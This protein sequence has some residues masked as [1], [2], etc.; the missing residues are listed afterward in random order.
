MTAAQLLNSIYEA[1]R[2][3]VASRTPAWGSDKGNL[4]I[5]IANRKQREWCTDPRNKWNSLFEIR[6]LSPVLDVT[7]TPTYTYNLAADFYQPSDFVKIVKNDSSIVVYPIVKAQQRNVELQSLYIHGSNPKK[8]T[9]S[10]IVDKGLEGATMY[11]PGYYLLADLANSTD[12][13][14]VDDPN[15]LVYATAAELARNDPAKEDNYPNLI[16]MANELYARMSN[17]NNDAGFGQPNAVVNFMPNVG[18]AVED[19]TL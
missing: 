8:I 4:A 14:L 6:A 10:Q 17:A 7:T 12:P 3:K 16:G 15:W 11:V 2:G 5:S 9:F 1:Y 13:V 18:D 19:W